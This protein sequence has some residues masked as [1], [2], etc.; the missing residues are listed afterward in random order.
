MGG[1]TDTDKKV[2]KRYALN[3]DAFNLS[4]SPFEPSPRKISGVPL[5]LTWCQEFGIKS[6]VTQIRAHKIG[7][8]EMFYGRNK[9]FLAKLSIFA[10]SMFQFPENYCCKG[11]IKIIGNPLL[12]ILRPV[13]FFVTSWFRCGTFS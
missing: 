11:V 3:F 2:L 1:T 4:H 9:I 8:F 6:R 10:P 12:C 13:R 5:K 7:H